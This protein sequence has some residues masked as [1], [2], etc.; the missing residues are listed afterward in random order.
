MKRVVGLLLSLCLV[1]LCAELPQLTSLE[2][3]EISL[4]EERVELLKAKLEILQTLSRGDGQKGL[5][6]SQ[7]EVEQVTK[8]EE[9]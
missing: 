3:L 8:M 4:L 1:A 7:E 9:S 6:V 2:D 5:E